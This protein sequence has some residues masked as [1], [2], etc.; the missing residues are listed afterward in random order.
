MD[1]T[2]FMNDVDDNKYIIQHI[3]NHCS[4][5]DL[6]VLRQVN[7]TYH[8]FID[9][10]YK[11]PLYKDIYKIKLDKRELLGVIKYL[12]HNMIRKSVISCNDYY[13]IKSNDF[14]NYFYEHILLHHVIFDNIDVIQSYIKS[15][16]DK[17]NELINKLSN[18]K[19]LDD[20]SKSND[21][22][23]AIMIMKHWSENF[24]PIYNQK[25]I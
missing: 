20:S 24:Y 23:K 17:A 9:K 3:L 14:N 6:I 16:Y 21:A 10:N 5:N 1:I 18:S 15:L 2:T 12:Q 19:F 25:M 22:Y 7:K 11:I 13:N 4:M 8:D